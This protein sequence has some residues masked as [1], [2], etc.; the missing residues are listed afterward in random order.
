MA[1]NS[2]FYDSVEGDPRTYSAADFAKAFGII[3]ENGVIGDSTGDLGFD[4]GGTNYTTIYAGRA[5]IQG[6]FVEV[7]GSEVI[8]P[9][10]GTYTGCIVIKVDI[11]GERKASISVRTD[12]NPQKDEAIYEMVLYNC[13]VSNGVITG[14]TDLRVQ[15]GALAKMSPSVV[16][17]GG[18]PNGVFINMGKYNNTGKPVKLFLTS[19]QPSASPL[20]HR[21]WIQIDNF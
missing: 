15:G 14:V 19:Q 2:Y 16:S 18:D 10:A 11:K 1:I 12:Q 5:T 21:I 13:N 20:E 4:I 17:W 8:T 7:V 3:L 9:P 6:H